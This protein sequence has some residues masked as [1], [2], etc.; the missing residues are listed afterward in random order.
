MS[1][2]LIQL[3]AFLTMCVDSDEVADSRIM[4]AMRDEIKGIIP[5]GA[6]AKIEAE[7]HARTGYTFPNNSDMKLMFMQLEGQQVQRKG[8]GGH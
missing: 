3:K 8:F 5:E 6:A 4:A 2:R 1:I 7:Q